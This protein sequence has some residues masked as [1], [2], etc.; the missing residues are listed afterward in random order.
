MCAALAWLSVRHFASEDPSGAATRCIVLD[1]T[2]SITWNALPPPAGGI[3]FGVYW[4][5]H[6]QSYDVL[7]RNLR[8]SAVKFAFVERTADGRLEESTRQRRS[9]AAREQDAPPGYS[10]TGARGE[11][12]CVV[13][14]DV[15]IGARGDRQ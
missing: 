15:R 3:E 2:D 14:S 12:T 13:V 5:E 10:V 4:S 9:L 7:F 6:F 11:Q 1:E 8:D